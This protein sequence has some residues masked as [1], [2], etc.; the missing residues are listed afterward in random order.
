MSDF[1]VMPIGTA[2]ELEFLRF[3]YKYIKE[4]ICQQGGTDEH[5]WAKEEYIEQTGKTPP[6]P[7]WDGE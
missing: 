4:T 7:Y 6:A 5:Y 1:E 2:A 3:F